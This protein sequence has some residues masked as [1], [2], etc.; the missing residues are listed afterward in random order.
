MA[1]RALELIPADLL[2]DLQERYAEPQRAYHSWR[3][4]SELLAYWDETQ[5]DL[6][7]PLAVLAAILFHDA[8]YEPFAKD[9]EAKSANLLLAK[10]AN[11]LSS[12][13]LALA[14][15]C[16]LATTAHELAHDLAGDM[17]NDMARFLDMDLAILAAP[18]ERFD[19]YE[20]EVRREYA[21]APDAAFRVG[22]RQVL[23][24]FLARQKLFFSDWGAARFEAA[25]RQNLTRSIA[26]L[27]LVA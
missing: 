13:D 11:W 10:A 16:I 8:V 19:E 1:N 21:A 17:Q 20:A 25:A 15:V 3:H 23:E 7:R 18:A 4:V 12:D 14:Y 27:N 24:R 6:R 26:A 9:N 2:S 5:A 22:R